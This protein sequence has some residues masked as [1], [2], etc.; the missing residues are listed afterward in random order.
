MNRA[1]SEGK[2]CKSGELQT[3]LPSFVLDSAGGLISVNAIE[4]AAS[5][6]EQ[7]IVGAKNA[8]IFVAKYLKSGEKPRNYLSAY[9]GW[10]DFSQKPCEPIENSVL[11]KICLSEHG[12]AAKEGGPL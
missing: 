3:S 12:D 7:S 8:A 5:A 9:F 6:I 4:S 10:Q 2:H 1:Q 11:R